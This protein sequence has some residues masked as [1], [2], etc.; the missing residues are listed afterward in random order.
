MALST[1]QASRKRVAQLPNQT[2]I[3]DAEISKLEGKANKVR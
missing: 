3:G 2:M 1:Y